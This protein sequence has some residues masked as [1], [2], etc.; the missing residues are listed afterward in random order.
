ME[1]G[2]K[3]ESNVPD[4][5][6]RGATDCKGECKKRPNM[7]A[8]GET[9][10]APKGVESKYSRSSVESEKLGSRNVCIYICIQQCEDRRGDMGF[11]GS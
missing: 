10:L 3:S 7:V 1:K 2:G 8:L 6:K 4:C 9:I 5:E 11:V